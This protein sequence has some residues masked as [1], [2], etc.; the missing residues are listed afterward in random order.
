MKIKKCIV[1]ILSLS[2][3]AIIALSSRNHLDQRVAVQVKDIPD[4]ELTTAE[5]AEDFLYLYDILKENYPYFGVLKRQAHHDWLAHKELYLQWIESTQDDLEYYRRLGNILEQLKQDHTNLISPSNFRYYSEIYNTVKLRPWQ[6]IFNNSNVIERNKYWSSLLRVKHNI[7]NN[8]LYLDEQKA[9]N[10]NCEIIEKNKIAYLAIQSF[11]Y[12]L[13][14]HDE[15]IINDFFVGIS[16]YPYLIIDI[17]GNGGGATAYWQENIIKPLLKE[18][19]EAT[20]YV[21][22]RNGAYSEPFVNYF[23]QESPGSFG[24]ELTFSVRPQNKKS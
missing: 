18:K 14:E 1:F 10:V 19:I 13:I 2:L 4:R 17:R 3:I 9:N 11:N 22:F 5:K 24:N 23:F 7:F 12:K 15:P 6:Q 16:H 8:D 21:A 20:F